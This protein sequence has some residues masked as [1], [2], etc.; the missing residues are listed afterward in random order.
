MCW[1]SMCLWKSAQLARGSLMRVTTIKREQFAQVRDRRES[2]RKA[3]GKSKSRS[4]RLAVL[5]AELFQLQNNF[6]FIFLILLFFVRW[7]SAATRDDAACPAFARRL[8]Y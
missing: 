1:I 4:H 6:F 5:Q 3:R 8:V 2:R 7:F